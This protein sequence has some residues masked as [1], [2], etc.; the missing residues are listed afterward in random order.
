M[1]L[2]AVAGTAAVAAESAEAVAESAADAV[3]QTVLK[4]YEL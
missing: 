3:A 4:N 2:F 1:L